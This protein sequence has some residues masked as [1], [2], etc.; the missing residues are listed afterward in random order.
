MRSGENAVRARRAAAAPSRARRPGAEASSHNASA[1]ARK[2]PTGKS[3]PAD[4]SSSSYGVP[5]AREPITG[6]PC[7][8]AS[9]MEL[10]M[11]S[12]SEA[13]T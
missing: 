4:P 11:P 9:R 1:S 12:P 13:E 5:A 10:D 3:R 7:A 2:S 8:I 6:R